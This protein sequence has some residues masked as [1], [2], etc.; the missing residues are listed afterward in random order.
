MTRRDQSPHGFEE[1]LLADL[2]AHVV[3]RAEPVPTA[4]T[5]GR[6]VRL[7]RGWRLAGAFGLAVALAAGGLTVQTMG[8]RPASTASAAE[9]FRLAADAAREQ[10][11]LV[12][13]PEQYVFTEFLATMREFP[14]SGPYRTSRVQMWQSAGG[15]AHAQARYRPENE[16]DGWGELRV[17]RPNDPADPEKELDALPSPAY[18]GD[19]PTDPDELLRYLR[20]HPVDLHLPESADEQAVYGGETM[21]YTTARSMLDGY[22]PPRALAALFELLAREPGAVVV[23][24]DV[25]D[26]AG[27]HGVAIRMPGV[28]GG[29]RDFVFDRDTHVYLGTRDSVVR[30]GRESPFSATALLRVAIVDRPGQLP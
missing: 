11:E 12:A 6:R 1:Q 4:R 16:P 20:E 15:L 21:P 18:H 10:P 27:R 24:G 28:I 29:S 30:N 23:P 19:L 17:L 3:R 14:D 7:P 8:D 5:V 2:K 25:V 26:A 9:I 13:R 22:V